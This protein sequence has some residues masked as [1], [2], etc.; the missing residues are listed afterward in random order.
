MY[1]NMWHIV[2]AIGLCDGT[3]SLDR[4][5]GFLNFVEHRPPVDSYHS[6]HVTFRNESPHTVTLYRVR[7]MKEQLNPLGL[8]AATLAPSET[9]K[10]TCDVGDTFTAKVFAP[11]TPN[12]NSLL[13]AHD[14]SRVY[15]TDQKC[16]DT[17]SVPCNRKPF[18]SEY[19]WTPPD[20]FLFSN[21]LHEPVDL[22]YWD[23]ACEEH[24]GHVLEKAD[25]HIQSTIGHTFRIRRNST[26]GL[27]H[28]Y[29]LKEVVI[30][31]LEDE[32]LEFSEKASALFDRLHV[33][34]LKESIAAHEKLLQ[35]LDPETCS[36][37]AL[38]YDVGLSDP[39][40]K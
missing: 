5:N 1:K 4:W 32:D 12:H 31:G 19:R 35:E 2:L 28:E 18:K 27:L 40:D 20:S 13:M 36:Q 25:H 10:L 33:S 7:S 3:H 14:V 34:V 37:E 15:I 8:Q 6:V 9:K 22:Y 16:A 26:Q 17:E 24:V 11:G 29:R 38:R 30:K 39:V 23:G 21:T